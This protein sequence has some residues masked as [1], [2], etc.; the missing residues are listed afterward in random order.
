MTEEARLSLERKRFEQQ[1]ISL[2]ALRHES[3]V[4]RLLLEQV[5][6]RT[7][8]LERM[9]AELSRRPE[10]PREPAMEAIDT[11]PLDASRT[12]LA[13]LEARNLVPPHYHVTATDDGAQLVCRGT[14]FCPQHPEHV[15]AAPAR[16]QKGVVFKC[17]VCARDVKFRPCGRVVIASVVSNL[18]CVRATRPHASGEIWNI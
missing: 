3:A 17:R 2:H 10:P 7:R 1:D 13:Q 9:L 14:Y 6:Q 11:F 5:A 8:T 16:V 15:Q 4:Q 18:C 12:L